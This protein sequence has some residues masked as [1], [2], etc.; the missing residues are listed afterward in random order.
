MQLQMSHK[1]FFVAAIIGVITVYII[2]FTIPNKEINLG[3]RG[4]SGKKSRS[5]VFLMFCET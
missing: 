1:V 4:K 2:S 5:T 3:K